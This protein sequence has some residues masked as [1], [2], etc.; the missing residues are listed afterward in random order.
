[1]IMFSKACAQA[2]GSR[3]CCELG[4]ASCSWCFMKIADSE[5]K[6]NK[7]PPMR[8][9][10]KVESPDYAKASKYERCVELIS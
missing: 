10:C 4:A 5:G 8:D 7:Q 2:D 3:I 9:L 1:M 6:S